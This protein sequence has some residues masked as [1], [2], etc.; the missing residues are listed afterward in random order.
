MIWLVIILGFASVILLFLFLLQRREIKSISR[1]LGEIKN[2]ETNALVHS[3]GSDKVSSD[4]INEINSL[5]RIVQSNRIYYEQKKQDLE[6]MMT[7]ISHDLRTPLTSAMGY[8]QIIQNSNLSEEEKKRELDVIKQRLVRLEELINSFFEFSQ[9]ISRG[10][11]PEKEEVNVVAIMEEAIINHFDDY[12]A[13]NREIIFECASRK[14]MLPSHKQMMQRIFDNVI[15]NAL[16]HGR[17]DL[18]IV[19][20]IG[21]SIK[22]IF[23]NEMQDTDIDIEHVFDEFY[24]TDISRTKGNTGLGLAM[25]KKY[26]EMLDGTVSVEDRE[27][28]FCLAV[29]FPAS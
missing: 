23:E 8:I 6:R 16:K 4:L 13:G 25:V 17:G 18:R 20:N 9:I 29:E 28:V 24:T 26:T 11:K 1:Q 12:S 10:Q 2:K 19:I 7:N 5:L 15:S 3:V 21:E 27:G 22:I 14:V